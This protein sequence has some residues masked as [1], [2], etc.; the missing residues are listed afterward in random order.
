MPR[1]LQNAINAI[2]SGVN[3][4]TLSD[5]IR[6]PRKAASIQ[7]KIEACSEERN[8][9]TEEDLRSTLSAL[10]QQ[11]QTAEGF[12]RLADI[13][14]TRVIHTD[15]GDVICTTPTGRDVSEPKVLSEVG[16]LGH[17]RLH[18]KNGHR[19]QIHAHTP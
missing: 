8:K 3:S 16:A 2:L 11:A 12:G 13:A 19:E 4:K 9:M 10:A 6:Q 15:D 14:V 18:S 5:T 7:R 17:E 1:E